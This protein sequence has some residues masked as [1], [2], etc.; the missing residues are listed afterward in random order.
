[1]NKTR[2]SAIESKLH[3]ELLSTWQPVAALAVR[4]K[5]PTKTA[6]TA[7]LQMEGRGIVKKARVRIDGHN[8]VHL[9]KKPSYVNVLGIMMPVASMEEL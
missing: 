9:F 7:L 2:L 5:I 1:M 3:T 8:L 6:L 4:C